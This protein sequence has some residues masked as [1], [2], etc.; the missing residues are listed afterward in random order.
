MRQQWRLVSAPGMRRWC[1]AGWRSGEFP[2]EL[3]CGAGDAYGGGRDF[4]AGEN[5]L[6]GLRRLSG[7]GLRGSEVCV[8]V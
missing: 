5:E 6:C 3:G 4:G 1:H 7:Q 8:S 2:R